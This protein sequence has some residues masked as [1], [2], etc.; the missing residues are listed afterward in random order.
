MPEFVATSRYFEA[1]ESF[2]QLVGVD[3]VNVVLDRP[4]VSQACIEIHIPSEY[5]RV[6]PR[7]H[8]AIADVDLGT[9]PDLSAHRPGEYVLV[10]V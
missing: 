6:P 7:I 4:D 8:R 2:E 5:D 1:A 10:V 3:A 9:R